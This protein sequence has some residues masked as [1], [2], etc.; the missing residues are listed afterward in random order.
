M[1]KLKISCGETLTK[2]KVSELLLLSPYITR[3]TLW[4]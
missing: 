1:V 4:N 3:T 2:A